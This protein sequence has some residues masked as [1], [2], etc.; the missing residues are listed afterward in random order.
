LAHISISCKQGQEF[1]Q[2]TSYN[3]QWNVTKSGL[4]WGEKLEVLVAKRLER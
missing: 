3:T 4:Q 2:L 1:E